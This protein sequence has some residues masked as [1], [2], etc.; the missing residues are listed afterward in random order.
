MEILSLRMRFVLYASRTI[1]SGIICPLGCHLP[2]DNSN[3]SEGHFGT[4]T[5]RLPE[6]HRR[7]SKWILESGILNLLA[8]AV[9]CLVP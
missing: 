1:L 6:Y 9:A 3:A 4:G 2:L 8:C 7:I 5:D